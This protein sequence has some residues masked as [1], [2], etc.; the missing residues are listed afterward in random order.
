MDAVLFF[1][2]VVRVCL[3]CRYHAYVSKGSIKTHS[4]G[5]FC[6]H[7]NVPREAPPCGYAG[8]SFQAAS[9]NILVKNKH[10]V[11]G[12]GGKRNQDFLCLRGPPVI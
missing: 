8:P 5:V 10:T 3:E 6:Y 7:E 2:S 11:M 9:H 4:N 12:P 1:I